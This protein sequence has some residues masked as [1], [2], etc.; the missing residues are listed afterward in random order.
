MIQNEP[1]I[2]N[3]NDLIGEGDLENV[4]NTDKCAE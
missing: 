2:I 1:D 4:Q 3:I